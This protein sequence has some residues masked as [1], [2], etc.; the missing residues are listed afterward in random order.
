M[1]FE[2]A[3]SYPYTLKGVIWMQNAKAPLLTGSPQSTATK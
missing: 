2:D 3:R 1:G